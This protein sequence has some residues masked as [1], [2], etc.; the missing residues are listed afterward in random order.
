MIVENVQLFN[1]EFYK[2]NEMFNF[3]CYNFYLDFLT[4]KPY[5]NPS[6][7]FV[8]KAIVVVMLSYF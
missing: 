6:Y 5:Q 3:A 8:V 1:K 7:A 4:I 2:I